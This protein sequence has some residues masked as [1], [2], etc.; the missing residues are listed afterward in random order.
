MVGSWKPINVN[1]EY[2]GKS[3]EA[4]FNLYK[5]VIATLYFTI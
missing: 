2:D 4:H 1:M 3:M 5:K